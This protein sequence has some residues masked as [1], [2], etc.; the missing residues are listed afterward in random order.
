MVLLLA[1]YTVCFL[2][3]D[4][5]QGFNHKEL[6]MDTIYKKNPISKDYLIYHY[7]NHYRRLRAITDYKR[8]ETN[9]PQNNDAPRC[10]G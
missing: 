8:V 5:K 4:K 6:N 1:T 2:L 7:S 3:T 10:M 9:T